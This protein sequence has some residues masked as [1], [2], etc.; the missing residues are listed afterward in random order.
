MAD[1]TPTALSV[2]EQLDVVDSSLVQKHGAQIM[3]I[4]DYSAVPPESFFTKQALEDGG[5]ILPNVLPSAY[6]NMGYITT[7]GIQESTDVSTSDVQA[8]QTI[9]TVRSDIDALTKTLQVTFLEVSGLT[10]SLWAG[11]PVV[12]W[13]ADKRAPWAVAHGRRSNW[14]YYR[15]FILTQD[16]AG[17]DAKYRVEHAYRAKVTDLG[18]RT[19]NRTDPET[20]QFTFTC[21]RDDAVGMS[22]YEA[23]AFANADQLPATPAA[24]LALE[25]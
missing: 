4:A 16:G 15:I 14:P 11:L 5:L 18:D 19:L 1:V 6:R 12:R 23:D 24:L 2:E 25:A 13:P 17:E 8:V 20:H 22:K 7:D 10:K 21:F 3:A 9:E